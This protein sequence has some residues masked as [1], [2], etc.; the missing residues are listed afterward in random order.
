MRSYSQFCPVARGAEIFAERWTP[1]ILRELLAGVSRYGELVRGLP[2]IPRHLLVKRL[3][4]LEY[5]RR[6]PGD[7]GRGGA[8]ARVVAF[9]V[10]PAGW[11]MP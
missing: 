10:P 3:V 9:V 2:G 5:A 4:G 6:V 1:L 11:V 8:P 7:R